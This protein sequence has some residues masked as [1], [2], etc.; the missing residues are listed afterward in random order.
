MLG[1]LSHG[2][3]LIQS[4]ASGSGSIEKLSGGGSGDGAAHPITFSL[5]VRPLTWDVRDS[6]DSFSLPVGEDWKRSPTYQSALSRDILIWG[7]PNPSC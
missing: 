7:S 4:M 3:H 5:A 6:F 2:R 1:H